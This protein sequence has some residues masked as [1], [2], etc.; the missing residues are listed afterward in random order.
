MIRGTT[1][2]FE[3]TLPFSVDLLAKAYI[4]FKQSGKIVL[5]KEL[6]ECSC[7]GNKI[8]L[9][10][11]QQDTLRFISTRD[12]HTRKVEIQIRAKTANGKA[13]ASNLMFDD[14]DRILKD[15]EI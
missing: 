9:N 10:L 11:T 13:I 2:S 6:N 1:P 8:V 3:F 15:G 14:V 5:D 12:V 4:T 7:E